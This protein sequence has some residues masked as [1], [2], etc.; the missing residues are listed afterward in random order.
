MKES[1][2]HRVG[3]HSPSLQSSM[4]CRPITPTWPMPPCASRFVQPIPH[5]DL[6]VPLSAGLNDRHTVTGRTPLHEAVMLNSQP[7]VRALLAMGA[8]PNLG[9]ISQVVSN[10]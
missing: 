1:F 8:D 2:R 6:S 7:I 5:I 3:L 10:L 9:H 4:I